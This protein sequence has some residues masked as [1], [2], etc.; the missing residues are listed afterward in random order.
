MVNGLVEELVARLGFQVDGLNQLKAAGV[1]MKGVETQVKGFGT[2]LR[3]AIGPLTAWRNAVSGASDKLKTGLVAVL[4]VTER[5]KIAPAIFGLP[6][7][8]P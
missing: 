1:A 3:G 2:R 5:V 4:P 7:S 6:R 8:E